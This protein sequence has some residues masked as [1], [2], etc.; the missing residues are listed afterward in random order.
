MRQVLQKDITQD[1][2][3]SAS[4]RGRIETAE[5][6]PMERSMTPDSYDM[7]TQVGQSIAAAFLK[8]G[9]HSQEMA[10]S[11]SADFSRLSCSFCVLLFLYSWQASA[12][13][14]VLFWFPP[15]VFV[16]PG[17]VQHVCACLAFVVSGDKPNSLHS[18]HSK[19]VVR[20]KPS[21]A[22]REGWLSWRS[23]KQW[24]SFGR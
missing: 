21:K 1:R 12:A 13:L 17:F 18:C 16:R 7:A 3:I 24:A 4:S 20:A 5:G 19:E 8:L 2:Q 10:I 9:S 11:F 22:S 23:H 14:S 15:F 6:H